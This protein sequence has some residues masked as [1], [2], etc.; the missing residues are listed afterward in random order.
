MASLN[1]L[2]PRTLLKEKVS[3]LVKWI[4]KFARYN[5]HARELFKNKARVV[6]TRDL[7]AVDTVLDLLEQSNEARLPVE[8]ELPN[9]PELPSDP[10]LPE[11]P[12][13]PEESE[14]SNEPD[15]SK[16]QE[17]PDEPGQPKESCLPNE[18]WSQIISLAIVEDYSTLRAIKQVSQHWGTLV[19]F[20]ERQ[21]YA[22]EHHPETEYTCHSILTRHPYYISYD[23]LRQSELWS[24]DAQLNPLLLEPAVYPPIKDLLIRIRS[25]RTMWLSITAE[26]S[27]ITVS[28]VLG[29]LNQAFQAPIT[30]CETGNGQ[31]RIF[32]LCPSS[33][34]SPTM[35]FWPQNT[36]IRPS[37]H[38]LVGESRSISP[39]SLQTVASIPVL[40]YIAEHGDW[41]P[42]YCAHH[43]ERL[44]MQGTCT[45]ESSSCIKTVWCPTS[46]PHFRT[47]AASFEITADQEI[48]PGNL[49]T[50]LRLSSID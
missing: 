47:L 8:L 37:Q 16:K 50:A 1:E 28:N 36:C 31:R 13:M 23:F 5:T 44:D 14:L 41:T 25:E 4:S 7:R 2:Q 48:V 29:C 22:Q 43:L 40:A 6:A 46:P 3:R 10:E 42:I 15:L 9:E 38:S 35:R 11:E 33:F 32:N 26:H 21:Y 18:L 34:P 45:H 17:L 30:F 24:E 19:E 39:H 27:Y 12:E 49:A 20:I